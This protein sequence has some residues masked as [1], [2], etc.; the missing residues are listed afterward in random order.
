MSTGLSEEF[1]GELLCDTWGAEEC[2]LDGI[3]LGYVLSA[4]LGLYTYFPEG[5]EDDMF[6]TEPLGTAELFGE[7]FG[8]GEDSFTKGALG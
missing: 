4:S 5:V 3:K 2:N 6:G 8:T 1:L 7:I